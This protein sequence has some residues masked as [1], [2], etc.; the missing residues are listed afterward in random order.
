[1]ARN[2]LISL[3][4][5]YPSFS[6]GQKKIADY[7]R[8]NPDEAAFLTAAGIS[9][10]TGVSESTV[11]RF[12]VAM[13]YKGFPEF[14]EALSKM[15]RDKL[16]LKEQVA[17][18]NN[19][20]KTQL[21]AS[22]MSSDMSLVADTVSGTDPVLFN[23]AVDMLCNAK[24]IYIIGIRQEAALAAHLAFYL[25]LMFMDA[26]AVNTSHVGELFEQ[27]ISLDENDVVVG[28]SFPRYSVRVLRALEYASTKKAG[29]ITIT[30]DADSPVR[31][32]S[33]VNLPASSKTHSILQSMTAP[34]SLINAL[35]VAISIKK[36]D[37]LMDSLKELEDI[38]QDYQVYG[39]DMLDAFDD[40]PF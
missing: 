18:S 19:I 30:D 31:M 26:R 7:V 28:I 35:V 39:P 2:L 10:K 23:A 32:Y 38:W 33:S 22:V 29:I 15:L 8:E 4:K 21:F 14:Q 13:G 36:G 27:L 25:N 16:S 9:E 37:K 34:F 12:A 11:V 6:K 5:K 1:M 24:R 40:E 20:G 3:N 17:G